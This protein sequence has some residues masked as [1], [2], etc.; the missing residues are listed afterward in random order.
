M[1]KILADVNSTYDVEGIIKETKKEYVR[2]YVVL[3]LW[4][5]LCLIGGLGAALLM[6]KFVWVLPIGAIIVL[7]SGAFGR[8]CLNKINVNLS[9]AYGEIAEVHKEV[10]VKRSIIG[11]YGMYVKREYDAFAAD[12]SAITVFIRGKNGATLSY[13]LIG[14]SERHVKYYEAKGEAIHIPRTVFP[15]KLDFDN[16]NWLCPI[17]GEFNGIH[18]KNCRSCRKRII[19]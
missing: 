19:K 3:A 13:V 2:N 7:V 6:E 18:D 14:V 11:G 12:T 10:R 9:A 16:E 15:V 8:R 17:C 4:A 5:L 1:N